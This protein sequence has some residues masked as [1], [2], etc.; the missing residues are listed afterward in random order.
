MRWVSTYTRLNSDNTAG[1]DN[2][3]QSQVGE[4]LVGVGTVLAT[5][6]VVAVESEMVTEAVGEEGSGGASSHDFVHVALE[7]ANVEQALHGNLVGKNV[8]LVIVDTTLEGSSGF[9]FHLEDN[10][11]N[12]ERLLGEFAVER[13]CASLK[14]CKLVRICN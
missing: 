14:D 7:D 5:A 6:S 10:V 11:V 8:R 4:Q 1:R 2:A 12:V 3:A 13:E 9:L